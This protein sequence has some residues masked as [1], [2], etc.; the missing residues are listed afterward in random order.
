MVACI[1]DAIGRVMGQLE[2]CGLLD[3]CVLGFTSDHSD[4]LGD[5]RLLLKGPAHY[6]S[7]VR[8]PFIWSDPALRERRGAVT[9]QLC[10]S[11]D[12]SATVLD[13]AGIASPWGMQGR[14]LMPVLAYD[15]AVRDGVLIEEEQQRRCFGFEKPPR[16]HTLVTDRWRLSVY[17][18]I[19]FGELYELVKDPLERLNRWDDASYLLVK[20][21]L[22]AQLISEQLKA[23]DQAPFPTA[24]A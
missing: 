21:D 18:D 7:L 12:L 1:D 9:Q 16:V 24:L 22:L 13:R 4:F 8:V 17:R 3:D 11:L 19:S 5:H 15:L 20:A 23:V 6:Q 2:Q 14:S 10:S